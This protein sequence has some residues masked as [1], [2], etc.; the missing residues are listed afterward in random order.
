MDRPLGRFNAEI[1]KSI[2]SYR[3]RIHA[4][5]QRHVLSSKKNIGRGGGGRRRRMQF[6]IVAR[7]PLRPASRSRRL[8][9]INHPRTVARAPRELVPAA[10]NSRMIDASGVSVTEKSTPISSKGPSRKIDA[11]CTHFCRYTC[12]PPRA[13]RAKGRVIAAAMTIADVRSP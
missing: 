3:P 9:L 12:M 10:N 4:C 13:S 7:L 8:A 1:S 2:Q 11:G 5:Y 6:P